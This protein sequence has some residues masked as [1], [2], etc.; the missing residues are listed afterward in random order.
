MDEKKGGKNKLSAEIG[1]LMREKKIDEANQ[2]KEKVGT[3]SFNYYHNIDIDYDGNE[4][5]FRTYERIE[6]ADTA[7]LS[8]STL[9]EVSL[10]AKK[11]M[12]HQWAEECSIGWLR[13]YKEKLREFLEGINNDGN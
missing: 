13:D 8:C 5:L 4:L 12:L 10:V 2:V 6:D 11:G 1:N 3:I 9:P 7:A